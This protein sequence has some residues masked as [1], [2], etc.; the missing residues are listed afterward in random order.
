MP[1]HDG[2]QAS[3]L[4]TFP[5]LLHQGYWINGIEPILHKKC[6][7]VITI[8]PKTNTTQLYSQNSDNFS[9]LVNV[10]KWA[11][12]IPI[13]CFP[14]FRFLVWWI[15]KLPF[16]FWVYP[17]SWV[18]SVCRDCGWVESLPGLQ[19]L[20]VY[21]LNPSS[22]PSTWRSLFLFPVWNLVNHLALLGSGI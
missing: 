9:L 2:D 21:V 15:I 19:Q 17:N 4:P 20:V 6:Q 13:P 18:V 3:N 1:H 10:E 22:Y 11:Y 12:G 16:P 14:L 7:Y 8:Y 5:R